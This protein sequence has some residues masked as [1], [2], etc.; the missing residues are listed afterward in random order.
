MS[1]KRPPKKNFRTHCDLASLLACFS[2]VSVYQVISEMEKKGVLAVWVAK[3]QRNISF[4]VMLDWRP[5]LREHNERPWRAECHLASF[6][7][8]S[9][10]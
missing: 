10:A 3:A 4:R 5:R 8:P 9:V 7:L 6:L 2:R 1:R